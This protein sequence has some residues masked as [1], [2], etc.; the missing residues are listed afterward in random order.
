MIYNNDYWPS[1]DYWP[2]DDVDERM[3]LLSDEQTIHFIE[4]FDSF[5]EK[6]LRG[7]DAFHEI[8][9]KL[10]GRSFGF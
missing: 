9:G 8:R 5:F 4:N 2:T 7:E 1:K 6:W 10:K 3:E